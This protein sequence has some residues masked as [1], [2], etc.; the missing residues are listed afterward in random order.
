LNTLYGLRSKGKAPRA[1]R[2]GRRV[3]YKLADLEAYVDENYDLGG[4]A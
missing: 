4:A 1:V 2:I 3:Q